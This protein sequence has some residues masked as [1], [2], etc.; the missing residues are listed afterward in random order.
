MVKTLKTKVEDYTLG[1]FDDLD[2]IFHYHDYELTLNAVE[3]LEEE[4]QK[5]QESY[6]HTDAWKE[7][8][9]RFILLKQELLK[10]MNNQQ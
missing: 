9:A 7:Q 2:F 1:I 4:I 8:N 3:D 5:D 6:G 10:L